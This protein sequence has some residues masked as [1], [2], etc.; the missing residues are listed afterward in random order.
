MESLNTLLSLFTPSVMLFLMVGIL[1]GFVIGAL[2]GLSA[3]MAIAILTPVTFWFDAEEGFAMLIGVW[4]SAVFAGGISAILLNTPGTPASV[5][6]TMD[7]YALYRKGKG[8]LALGI[9]VIYS[10][11]GGLMSIAACALFSFP[12]ARFAVGFG[13]TEY[14]SLALFGL[15]MMVLVSGNNL[16]KGL[17][18]GF[19]GVLLSTIGLD[20]MTAVKR[21]TFGQTALLDGIP[22]IA[23]MIGMFGVGEVFYQIYNRRKATQAEN[24][25]RKKNLDI[26]RIIPNRKEFKELAVPACVSS[27]IGIIVGAI[28]ACGGD[29]STIIA[30]GFGKKTSKHPEEYGKGSLEGLCVASTSNNSVIGGALTTMLALGIPGDSITAILIGAL[31]MYGMTPGT[32]MF[33]E[34]VTFIYKILWLCVLA[35]IIFLVLG[36]LTTRMS[37]KIISVKQELVWT[38]VCVFCIVGSFAIKNSYLDVCIM[39]IGGVIGFLAKRYE[40]PV[41][42][43]ILGMILSPL[44]ES[45]LRRALL[46]SRGSLDIF[47]TR[48]VTVVILI[49]VAVSLFSEPISKLIKKKMAAKAS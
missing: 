47:F 27:A 34:N 28:P 5:M 49:L 25:E 6:Q 33:T 39:F 12:I 48:P 30:W 10:A 37:A 24:L 14:F 40:Y 19:A 15:C 16:M 2:P 35:N 3:T 32:Q 44:M 18:M 8:G 22:Y 11:F 23:L 26:G 7:G 43:F 9:N 13:P 36:L 20:P 45:N 46:I 21:Y 1:V 38:L 42:P 17:A 31:T 29:I 41:G 4:N